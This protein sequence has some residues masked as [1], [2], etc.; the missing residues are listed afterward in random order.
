VYYVNEIGGFVVRD[1]A[2]AFLSDSESGELDRVPL[3][4]VPVN[5]KVPIGTTGNFKNW[6]CSN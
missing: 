3:K 4:H 6:S 2:S 1:S 5:E